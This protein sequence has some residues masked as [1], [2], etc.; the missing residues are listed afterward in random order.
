MRE[1]KMSI[2]VAAT[3]YEYYKDWGTDGLTVCLDCLTLEEKEKLDR[4][5]IEDPDVKW[6]LTEEDIAEIVSHMPTTELKEETNSCDRCGKRLIELDS[7][8][9]E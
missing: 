6:Y 2:K 4:A 5:E 3:V 8:V 9:R 1:H 7:V